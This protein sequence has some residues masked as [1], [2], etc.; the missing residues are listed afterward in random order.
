MNKIRENISKNKMEYLI[1]FLLLLCLVGI[2]SLNRYAIDTYFFEAFGMK[3]NA[4]NPYYHDGR[5]FMTAFL[6]ICDFLKL[7]YRLEKLLSWTLAFTSLFFAIIIFYNILKKYNKNNILN[8]IL[9]VCVVFN[10]F[11]I[12]FFMFPEYTGIMCLSLLFVF[13]GIY[14]ICKYFDNKKKYNLILALSSSIFSTLC[15]QGTLSLIFIIPLILVLKDTKNF[16][17]FFQKIL[18]IG[19]IFSISALSIA[20]IT[21]FLGASRLASHINVI[22]IVKNIINGVGGLLTTTYKILPNYF[23]LIFFGISLIL[24]FIALPKKVNTITFLLLNIVCLFIVPALPHMFTSYVWMVP[25]S[26]IGYGLLAVFPILFYILYAKV[27]KYVNYVFICLMC[28][29]LLWQWHS[30]LS[31]ANS[32]IIN[33]ELNTEEALKIGNYI[34]NYE[35]EF[36]IKINK[37]KT[38]NDKGV[39][40]VY[41]F[42][43]SAGDM[44]V[45]AFGYIWA[46]RAVL[47]NKLAR[48]FEEGDNNKEYKLYCQ[49]NNWST[50][51]VEQLKIIDD[52][53]HI[54]IY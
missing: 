6:Y 47:N 35:Q 51:D 21:K 17:D 2:F 26:N 36:N 28:L 1:I 43:K 45:R 40:Y 19:I 30:S 12:E 25:R 27:K 42:L 38:Y 37:I 8:I 16:K 41:P 9:S 4:I 29:L 46:Y 31:F 11:V 39:T 53:I 32:Q 18:T 54:C 50:F 33:N 44:N 34:N 20:L 5:L 24:C 7:S 48:F 10:P 23:L 15:Y 14:F 13:I 22:K 52:T 3:N 49:N